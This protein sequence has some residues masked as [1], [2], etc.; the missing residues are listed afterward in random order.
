MHTNTWRAER[1]RAGSI[2]VQPAVAALAFV[3]GSCT[4]FWEAGRGASWQ[5]LEGTQ[6]F[7]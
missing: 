6:F 1:R 3:P 7:I 2:R 4:L 5:S